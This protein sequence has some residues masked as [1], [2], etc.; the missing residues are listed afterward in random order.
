MKEKDH[1]DTYD[2]NCFLY[3]HGITFKEISGEK[4]ENDC[5]LGGDRPSKL[6]S[7]HDL[8]DIYNADEFGL[9]HEILPSET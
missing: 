8:H 4:S 2:L 6:L 1:S 7:R 5:N 9:F 3:R